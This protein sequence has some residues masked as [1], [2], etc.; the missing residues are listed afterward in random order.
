VTLP[1]TYDSSYLQLILQVT[2]SQGLHVNKI[3]MRK[4]VLPIHKNVE[5]HVSIKVFR[6]FQE[7]Q[8]RLQNKL[9]VE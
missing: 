3:N 5:I 1:I 8:C 6:Q 2:Q 4:K 7:G 9:Q